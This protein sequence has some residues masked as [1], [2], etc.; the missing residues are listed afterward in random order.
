[1]KQ[2]LE[3][4]EDWQRKELK[5]PARR[6]KFEKVRRATFL[7][8]RIQ[9]VRER[10]GLTQKE[11]ADRM[12]MKQSALARIEGGEAERSWWSD[13]A[14]CLGGVRLAAGKSMYSKGYGTAIGDPRC[15][16]SLECRRACACHAGRNTRRRE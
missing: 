7:A 8:Y 16:R 13:S 9:G 11:F 2:K 15:S 4:F 10:L 12:G 5:S 6:R 14:R 1:M 3:R